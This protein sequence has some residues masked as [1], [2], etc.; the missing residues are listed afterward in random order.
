MIK[1]TV[2]DRMNHI[3][4]YSCIITYNN[5]IELYTTRCALITHSI[6]CAPAYSCNYLISHSCGSKARHKII[7]IQVVKGF[8]QT[9]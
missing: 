5:K 7:Q 6:T 3:L 9:E 8:K 4:L 2:C 1:H